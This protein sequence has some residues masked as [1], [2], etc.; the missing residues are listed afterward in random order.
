MSFQNP[1]KINSESEF[2]TFLA[3]VAEK[4]LPSHTA[5][6]A[7]WSDGQNVALI[8]EDVTENDLAFGAGRSIKNTLRANG[9]TVEYRYIY[10]YIYMRILYI[11]F[12]NS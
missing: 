7:A 8:Q 12:I 2:G 11:T 4:K 3:P 6:A 9:R 5:L 10:N 1:S